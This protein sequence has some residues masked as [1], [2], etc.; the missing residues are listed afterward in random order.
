MVNV[1]HAL[2]KHAY[3][4]HRQ[5]IMNYRAMQRSDL[6]CVYGGGGDQSIPM[7]YL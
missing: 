2:K 5:G 3:F 4:I 1:D 6:M 7:K